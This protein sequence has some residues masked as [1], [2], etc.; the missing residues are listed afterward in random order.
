MTAPVC[1]GRKNDSA[2]FP[3]QYARNHCQAST[4]W[5]H[6]RGT[7]I[8]QSEAREGRP[9]TRDFHFCPPDQGL[10]TPTR[11][12]ARHISSSRVVSLPA[13]AAL[14][15]EPTRAHAFR[16]F[17]RHRPTLMLFLRQS[18]AV[19][20]R[21]LSSRHW[22]RPDSPQHVAQQPPGQMPL[23]QQEP[24]VPRMLHQPA[25]RFHQ[26]LLETR[27]RPA[28]DPRRQDQSPP[29][30]A[31]VVGQDAQLQAHFVRPEPMARQP[32]PVRRLLAFLDP[33]FR[34]RC[35]TLPPGPVAA[36]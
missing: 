35:G 23:C 4:I 11:L 14:D 26:P 1:P 9:S 16:A 6:H 32:R 21:P 22:Q 17:L 19:S 5:R 10:S 20:G 33:D 2:C 13:E 12:S 30:V 7:C 29:Q 15:V 25:P 28:L 8:A 27:E 18:S 31:Q 24:V 34:F 36:P 3:D